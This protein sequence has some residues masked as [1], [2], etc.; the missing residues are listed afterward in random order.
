MGLF[1]FYPKRRPHGQ[2]EFVLEV[3]GRSSD[4]W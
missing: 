2:D 4:Q 1:G 3:H